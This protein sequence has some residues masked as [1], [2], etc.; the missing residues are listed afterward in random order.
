M[1]GTGQFGV[2]VVWFDS[3]KKMSLISS[4]HAGLGPVHAARARGSGVSGGSW[5]PCPGPRLCRRARSRADS[6]G[7][8]L[9]GPGTAQPSPLGFPQGPHLHP[10]R[11]DS[12]AACAPHTG[13]QVVPGRRQGALSPSALG[14]TVWLQKCLCPS[15]RPGS[16]C[17]QRAPV[18]LSSQAERHPEPEG[19]TWLVLTLR[20][21]Q[22]RSAPSRALRG[23]VPAAQTV[24]DS[25]PSTQFLEEKCFCKTL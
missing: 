12:R 3:Q 14:S 5:G 20:S 21:Q 9:P 7:C 6:Q 10:R 4:R 15:T 2:C 23:E 25:N 1:A 8:R 17:V 24:L 11:P 19:D 22:Q 18:T 13:T 16:V